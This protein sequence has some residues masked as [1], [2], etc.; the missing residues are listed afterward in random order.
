MSTP[1]KKKKMPT[2]D[3][4]QAPTVTV[5]D[6]TQPVYINPQ[7]DQAKDNFDALRKLLRKQKKPDGAQP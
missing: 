6:E 2:E 7:Q 4:D 5:T 1:E 3:P